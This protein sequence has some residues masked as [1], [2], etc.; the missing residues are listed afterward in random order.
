MPISKYKVAKNKNSFLLDIVCL[1]SAAL[2]LL[3]SF[4]NYSGFYFLL[5]LVSLCSL[6]FY[7]AFQSELK[8]QFV[9]KP[10]LCI[11]LLFVLYT[12]YVLFWSYL[13]GPEIKFFDSAGRL[14]FSTLI[15]L[16]F[17]FIRLD[18][19]R[20][21]I[22]FKLYILIFVAGALSYFYQFVYGPI[23]WFADEPMERGSLFRFSTILG[24]GNIYGIGVGGALLLVGYSYK[25]VFIKILLYA[26]L[27]LGAFMSLQKAA[28][29]NIALWVL[30]LLYHSSTRE[31]IKYTSVTLILIICVYIAGLVF[32]GHFLTLYLQEFIFNSIGLNIYDNSDLIKSTV[33]DKENLF[34]RFVGLH[35]D[36]IF[37]MHNSIVI[38]LFGVGVMGAGGG[39]GLPEFPQA[40]STYWDIFFMGG[41]GYFIVFLYFFYRI[42]KNLLQHC[43]NSSRV[44]FAANI[45]LFI[46]SFSATASI[47][48]PVLSFVFWL[49]V[50]FVIQGG[51]P[52][53][54]L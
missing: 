54:A 42:N 35:L 43:S 9:N 24:S 41:L 49:S 3:Q 51:D 44:L 48:H 14:F 7:S 52:K 5:L 47:Y 40:H 19:R 45:L 46:N 23:Y 10:L 27:L 39:M 18:E 38:I 29:V 26:T 16:L 34:E 8:Q 50:I 25:N 2:L 30:I 20:L 22:L 13:Y 31:I 15:P 11:Y 17:A 21:F 37:G 1:S 4:R 28:I 32:S 12:V 53:V 33:L 6:I 36:E